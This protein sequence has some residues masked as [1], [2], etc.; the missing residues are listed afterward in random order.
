[1][2]APEES[3]DILSATVHTLKTSSGSNSDEDNASSDGLQYAKDKYAEYF[4]DSSVADNISTFPTFAR[5]DLTLGKVLGKGGFGTVYEIRGVKIDDKLSSDEG[6]FI[7]KHCLREDSGD[8]RYAVKVL[9]EEHLVDKNN[10]IQGTL[11]MAI[12]TRILS[13]TEHPNIIKARALAVVDPFHAEY[14]IMMDRLYDTLG[15]RIKKWKKGHKRVSGFAS[16]IIDKRGNKK[17][18]LLNARLVAAFDLS[19]AL[20]YLH[21]KKLVYRDLKPENIGFDIRDDVKLFDFGLA[22][23]MRES[24]KADKD[25]LYLLTGMTGSPRYMAPEVANR[26]PYNEKCDVYSFALVLWEMLSLKTP[27]GG[28]C[29]MKK[30]KYEVWNGEHVRPDIDPR[31]RNAIQSL[32]KRS[33]NPVLFARPS[34]NEITRILRQ[35]CMDTNGGSEVGLSHSRRRSTFIFAKLNLAKLNLEDASEAFSAK[36]KNLGRVGEKKQ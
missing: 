24:R 10:F 12:E 9:S 1:M 2:G 25:G 20:G 21:R 14:F 34:F 15:S 6:K 16:R 11:D 28:K 19:D 29:T 26:M 23:E 5:S 17:N 13:D 18:E 3:S 32:L 30:L 27:Y 7:A 33:W 8:S 22:G 36:F 35:Q 4:E 31:W